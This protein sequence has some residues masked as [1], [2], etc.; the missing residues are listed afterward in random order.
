MEDTTLFTSA[1][2]LLLSLLFFFFFFI[3][4][5]PSSKPNAH[6]RLPPSPMGLPVVGH[7]HLLRPP[8]HRAF[9]RLT[10]RHGP[11]IHV[12][13]GSTLCVV[14]A[15]A[16]VARDLLKTHDA[17]FSD[18]PQTI[19]ARRFAYDS[20]AFAFAPYSPYYRFMRRLC[21]SE[22]LGARTVDQL[23]PIRR[24]EFTALLHTLL[25]K[26]KLRERV[27]LSREL[28]R[29]TNNMVMRMA[30][31]TTSSAAGG[32]AEEARELAKQVAELIGA[33]N[34]EDH[35]AFCRGWDP[36]GLSKRI[37]DVHARFDGLL[38]RIIKEKEEARRRKK[39]HSN[40]EGGEEDDDGVVKDVLDILL[41]AAEDEK[42][43]TKLSRENIKGFIV[44]IFTAGSDT[45]A[46]S[47]EWV[48]AE[49]LNHPHVLQKLRREIDQVVGNG[50]VVDETDLPNLPYLQAAV[51]EIMRLHPPAPL[52]TRLATRDVT[53]G[54]Y[55]IP[56]GSSL[57][58]NVWSVGR[59]PK[60]WEN[61][62]EFRPERFVDD[63]AA[64][65]MRGQHFQLIPFGSGRRWCPGM[66]LALQAVPAAFA[67]LVQCFDWEVS[68]D[69]GSSSSSSGQEGKGR[70]VDMEEGV[71][72]VSARAHP[73]ILVPVP[74]LDPFPD[75]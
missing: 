2:L 24:A 49:T 46:A 64:V 14:A 73:L 29:L 57:F 19:A 44:D 41:D 15:G 59:D 58:V 11:L 36:Q 1:L 33:F 30:A 13:L 32:E 52:I 65:D 28:I 67:A 3:K 45:T 22:L 55:D 5:R 75:I 21:M 23:R 61:P 66:T 60:Y 20:A 39:K 8:I 51:K 27:N 69:S 10:L 71:G 48:L 43:E 47:I 17:A 18:R 42:A 50:R 7:L 70:L 26:S 53:V 25:E 6:Y 74:R 35:I 12:R 9:H 37:R 72:L 31:S 54:G 4:A 38:E 62:S 40:R 68:G 56:A 63:R 34:V 16:D